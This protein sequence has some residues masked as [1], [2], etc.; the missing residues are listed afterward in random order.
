M[1]H[2]A[3][4]GAQRTFCSLIGSVILTPSFQRPCPHNPRAF[5][6]LLILTSAE[7]FSEFGLGSSLE[8]SFR[9]AE[10]RLP[11]SLLGA[12]ACKVD[13]IYVSIMV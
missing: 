7:T 4:L 3:P 1:C 13:F 10:G 9:V 8:M 11:Q 5:I 12:V 2:N 6:L